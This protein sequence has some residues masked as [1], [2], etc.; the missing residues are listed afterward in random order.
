[1][2]R[3]APVSAQDILLEDAEEAEEGPGEQQDEVENVRERDN[4]LPIADIKRLIE[5]GG[6]MRHILEQDLS[7]NS[8]VRT[9]LIIQACSCCSCS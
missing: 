7:V 9:S 6:Q 1:M 3:P 4:R 8:E 2:L 5:L